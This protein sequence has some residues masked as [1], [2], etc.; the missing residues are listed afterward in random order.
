MPG[1][2]ASVGTAR[3]RRRVMPAVFGPGTG[4]RKSSTTV[5]RLPP[6][7]CQCLPIL[8]YL[9]HRAVKIPTNL[10]DLGLVPLRPPLQQLLLLRRDALPRLLHA[11]LRHAAALR[12][13]VGEARLLVGKLL[14]A[15]VAV[16]RDAVLP[17]E[18]LLDPRDLLELVRV[19][20][21]IP[22]G[23]PLAERAG[24][25]LRRRPVAVARDAVAAGPGPRRAAPLP[26]PARRHVFALA[27]VARK[28][29]VAVYRVRQGTGLSPA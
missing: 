2:S 3:G 18:V 9:S 26:R 8:W 22:Q 21:L 17:P 4:S 24:P 15:H 23:L 28:V 16:R 5:F 13:D 6:N 20:A 12:P 27:V 10:L 14:G 29:L 1:T 19:A 11:A 25:E 7:A